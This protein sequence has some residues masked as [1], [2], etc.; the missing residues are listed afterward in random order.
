MDTATPQIPDFSES[1]VAHNASSATAPVN[2]KKFMLAAVI[3]GIILIPLIGFFVYTRNQTTQSKAFEFQCPPGYTCPPQFCDS[4]SCQNDPNACRAGAG[5]CK[6]KGSCND[7]TCWECRDQSGGLHYFRYQN[8]GWGSCG[9]AT[10]TTPPSKACSAP[11]QCLEASLCSANNKRSDLQ[12]PAVSQV[13]C[14]PDQ[15]SPTQPITTIP[16]LPTDTPSPTPKP[17]LTAAP[18]NTPPVTQA[19]ILPKVKVTVECL[20]CGK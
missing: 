6:P 12:C 20:T 18:T 9:E 15:P 11:F 16:P 14:M 4:T 5:E 7:G 2:K 10:P 8:G 3:V 17:T 1:K 19:C 13:C